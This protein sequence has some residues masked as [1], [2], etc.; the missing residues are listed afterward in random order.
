MEDVVTTQHSAYALVIDLIEADGALLGEEL[1]V[2]H[3]DKDLFN[4]EVS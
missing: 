2:L 3:P 1:P 4:V